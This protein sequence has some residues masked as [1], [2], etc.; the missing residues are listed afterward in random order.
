MSE[1]LKGFFDSHCRSCRQ[2]EQ[3]ADSSW[4]PKSGWWW[5]D[6]N[7]WMRATMFCECNSLLFHPRTDVP[8]TSWPL[9]SDLSRLTYDKYSPVC[10]ITDTAV[11]R[12]KILRILTLIC[13]IQY[14]FRTSKCHGILK[15]KFAVVSYN[16]E[17]ENFPDLRTYTKK[18]KARRERHYCR[19]R[20]Q[21]LRL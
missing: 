18:F 19:P 16:M 13:K 14:F 17:L 20:N 11:K 1:N 4:S 8:L 2:C 7:W 12:L 6:Y 5:V 15:V 21:S 3:T 9:T 10:H